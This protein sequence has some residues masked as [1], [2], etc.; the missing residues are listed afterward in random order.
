MRIFGSEGRSES[1]PERTKGVS[2]EI[3]TV[4]FFPSNFSFAGSG[5]G[6]FFFHVIHPLLFS[7]A[8]SFREVEYINSRV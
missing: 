5:E 2:R 6:L 8:T 3:K 4:F 7:S 1:S